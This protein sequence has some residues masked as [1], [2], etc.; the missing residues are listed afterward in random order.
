MSCTKAA[1]LVCMHGWWH[2]NQTLA[3]LQAQLALGATGFPVLCGVLRDERGDT[4]MVRGALEC[5][6]VATNPQLGKPSKQARHAEAVW[7]V[8]SHPH[9]QQLPAG[10]I[11]VAVGFM[12]ALW[13]QRTWTGH[14]QLHHVFCAGA[15]A[16]RH[17]CGAV[18][19]RQGLC[20]AA[21]EPAGRRAGRLP[22]LLCALPH[23]A[24]VD[25]PVPDGLLPH[26]G[27]VWL[28]S[29]HQAFQLHG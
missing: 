12:R 16:C 2:V 21:A 8:L 10:S 29:L 4:E 28:A 1:F 5:L 24:A 25:S 17:Q 20:A 7:E 3:G 18:P 9:L 15:A 19:A 22:R 11:K 14:G 6:L 26:P 27:G 13:S 23:R